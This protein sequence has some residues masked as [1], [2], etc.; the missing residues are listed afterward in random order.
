M[1]L[2]ERYAV[3]HSLGR[4]GMGEV[5]RATDEQLGRAVAVKLMLPS[6]GDSISA[7]RF[8]REARAAAMLSDPHLVAVYDFGNYGD[9]FF[10][11][12]ELV[13][14]HTVAAELAEH[15]PLPRDRAIDIVEQSAAGLAAAHHEDVVHRDIKPGNLLLTSDGTVKVADFGIAHV[16]GDGSTTLTA[17]GQIIGSVRYLAPERARGGRGDKE[18]DVYALGCVLYELVTGQPPFTGEHPT[19]VLYQHVDTEPVPPSAIRPELAGAFETVLLRMLAKDPAGRPTAAEVAA[20]AL[21]ALPLDEASDQPTAAVAP[22][23]LSVDDAAVPPSPVQ[24]RQDRRNVLV[25]AAIAVVAA[26]L[27]AGVLIFNDGPRL[28]ATTDVGPKPGVISGTPGAKSTTVPTTGPTRTDG[29]NQ[30]PSPQSSQD[31]AQQASGTPQTPSPGDPSTGPRSPSTTSP[32]G[33]TASTTRSSAPTR[34]TPT[35]TAS[36]STTPP[37]DPPTSTPPAATPTPDTQNLSTKI[38]KD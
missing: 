35:P 14:G 17:V 23:V 11:V 6:D 19:A 20:G 36:Q 31:A 2:A 38:S 22:E 3:G 25:A 29:T 30:T 26:T 13:E 4:G 1:L 9:Q 12:M 33:P 27:L 21:R 16:P 24:P 15:G 37:A 5:F 10:L 32:S 18:S 8:R 28:P 7:E 34:A